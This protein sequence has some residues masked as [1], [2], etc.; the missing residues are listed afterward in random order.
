MRPLLEDAIRSEDLPGLVVTAARS[1]E[2]PETVCAGCDVRGE[3]LA[4]DSLFPVASVTK[5]ATALAVLRLA[6]RGEL[7]LDDRLGRHVPEAAA[8]GATLR[9]LLSHTAGLPGDPPEGAVPYRPGLTWPSVAAACVAVAPGPGAGAVVAYSNVGPGLLAVVVERRTGQPFTHALRELV[10]APLGLEA[11]LGEEPPRRPAALADVTGEH[12]GTELEPFNSPFWR[13]LALPWGGLVTTPADALALVRAFAGHPP[14]FLS[15]TLRVEA[16]SNQTAD[17][18]GGIF[19]PYLWDRCPWGLGPE[20]R[21]DK[22]P[23][24][25]APGGN[26]DSF[27]H[28]GSS[29]CLVWADPAASVAWGFFGA[30]IAQSG[31]PARVG[32]RIGDAVLA[33]ARGRAGG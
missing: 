6:D 30:R 27:G 9:S 10:L 2:P 23:H 1:G 22:A 21:G 20:L 7:G 14:G 31:W 19:P 25:G 32:P 11:Y 24:L 29:G 15:E 13:S 18:A 17:R 26:P 33:L 28:G 12:Q 3:A 5:L 16:I 4:P 8:A